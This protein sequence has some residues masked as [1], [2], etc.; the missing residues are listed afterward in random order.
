MD[1]RVDPHRVFTDAFEG[2]AL[3]FNCLAASHSFPERAIWSFAGGL[4]RLGERTRQALARG[5][6]IDK[7]ALIAPLV[8]HPAMEAAIERLSAARGP[9]GSR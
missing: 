6:L 3:L 4:E 5:G 9:G 7:D 2:I 8:V 1:S